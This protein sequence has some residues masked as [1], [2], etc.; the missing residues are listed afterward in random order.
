MKYKRKIIRFD[1]E[2][3]NKCLEKVDL[4]KYLGLH[5]DKKLLWEYH[6][7]SMPSKEEAN[8]CRNR[9]QQNFSHTG[10]QTSVLTCTNAKERSKMD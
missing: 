3:H 1:Y 8:H 7:S 2:I 9:L 10:N 6:G 4:A 5:I